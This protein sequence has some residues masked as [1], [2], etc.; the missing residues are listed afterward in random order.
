[1]FPAWRREQM[2]KKMSKTEIMDMAQQIARALKDL[3]P[4]DRLMVFVTLSTD[5]NQKARLVQNYIQK[6]GPIP[7]E[8]ADKIRKALEV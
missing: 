3:S 4:I 1:M 5:K 6:H 8:Y 7:N 2:S